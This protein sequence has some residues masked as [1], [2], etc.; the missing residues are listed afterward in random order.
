M[1]QEN[2]RH[3]NVRGSKEG[4]QV[5]GD[6]ICVA[7]RWSR[8]TP[9]KAGSIVGT[10]LSMLGQL[11]LYASPGQPILSAAS[12][13]HDGWRSLAHTLQPHRAALHSV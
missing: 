11:R 10:N 2:G 6:V 4:V 8:I 12:L 9:S 3:L 1:S 7:G 13:E 5:H